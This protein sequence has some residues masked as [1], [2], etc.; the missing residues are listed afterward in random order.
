V[1]STD[2]YVASCRIADKCCVTAAAAAALQY[3]N[4]L[5]LTSQWGSIF[6]RI[7]LRQSP[8]GTMSFTV[9]KPKWHVGLSTERVAQLFS[10]PSARSKPAVW[11]PSTHALLQPTR[12][13]L[14][15]CFSSW[16]IFCR[17]RTCYMRVL[18]DVSRRS[19][20]LFVSLLAVAVPNTWHFLLLH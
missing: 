4:L 11:S 10:A 20:D 14:K 13:K 1:T 2:C 17:Q 8:H 19:W 16:L 7:V 18:R 5:I 15:A 12:T 6:P 9:S 3:V